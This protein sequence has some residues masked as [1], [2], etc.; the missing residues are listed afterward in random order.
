MATDARRLAFYGLLGLA[1]LLNG[2]AVLLALR[3]ALT[4]QP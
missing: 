2:T 4:G 1:A 3:F